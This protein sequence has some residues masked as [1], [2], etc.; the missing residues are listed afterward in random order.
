[1]QC[2]NIA[3]TTFCDLY[4]HKCLDLEFLFNLSYEI[5]WILRLM[6]HCNNYIFMVNSYV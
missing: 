5:M 3:W 1:M 6:I 4:P 2:F